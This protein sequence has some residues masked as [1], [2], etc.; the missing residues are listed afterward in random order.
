MAVALLAASSEALA[1]ATAPVTAVPLTMA[2][3]FN[4]T[5]ITVGHELMAIADGASA[6]NGRFDLSA[7]GGLAGDPIQTAIWD[8]V[9]VD[10]AESTTGYSAD[11]WHHAAGVHIDASNRTAYIDGG[12]AGS[13]VETVTPVSIDRL[14]IG[15]TADSSP[16]VFTNGSIA[17]AA[18][19]NVA[20][21]AAEVA[22]LAKG[23][24]PLLVRPSGLVFYAPLI[25]D[26]SAGA[27]PELIGGVAL[28]ELNTPTV[29]VHTRVYYPSVPMIGFAAA[30][31]PPVG[32]GGVGIRNPMA[33]PMTLRTPMGV[34]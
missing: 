22:I 8:S 4:V 26:V 32:G 34:S 15:S 20:L 1:L 5:N 13:S 6:R 30:G 10:A 29:G 17:E 3:W 9:A 2:C 7:S 18:I 28:T 25:R 23:Y 21:S 33:G 14:R 16:A 27:W 11:T 19:W 31:A 12:S 24:S